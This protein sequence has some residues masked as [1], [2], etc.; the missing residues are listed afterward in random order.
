MTNSFRADGTGITNLLT[1]LA[2]TQ[3]QRGYRVIVLCDGADDVMR[4]L[5][6]THAIEVVEDVWSSSPARLWS[7][8]NRVAPL[9]GAADI[10]HV[11]TVRGALVS[12]V[13]SPIGHATKSVAT[14]HNPYQRSAAGMYT[15]A[16]IVAISAADDR[17]IRRQLAGTRRPVIVRNAILGSPRMPRST[18][19][20]VTLPP[21]SIVFVGALTERKGVDVLLRAM[22]QVRVAVRS[23]QLVVVGNR[24]NPGMEALVDELGL[25]PAVRFTGFE[26]DPRRYI[27]S[28]AVFVLP[29]RADGFP[30]ALL[31]AR[32]CG[33]PIVAT[34]VG[35]IP[36]ALSDGTA[37]LMI[38]PGNEDALADA[39]T[40]VLTDAALAKELRA[41]SKRGLQTM[42]V[43]RMAD[44]YD[45][46]YS[47]LRNR[48]RGR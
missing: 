30:L 6:A 2:V 21:D 47:G 26:S 46:V 35:G 37:G 39:L 10:V 44:D 36:E 45:A 1:D 5:A 24:D 17:S 28:A 40:R 38:P 27:A 19:E 33:V 18:P 25:D 4:A 13:A 9:L 20:P 41:A 43:D 16:R 23:A 42:T 3:A 29:S 15:A 22:V 48:R 32:S 34:D 31:E 8:A 11:H 7:S 14:I 12:M